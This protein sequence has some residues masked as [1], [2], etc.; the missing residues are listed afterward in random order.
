MRTR[1][2]FIIILSAILT[3]RAEAQSPVVAP[4]Q[5]KQVILTG[6]TIHTG[7]G[8]VIED[9]LVA[10]AAGKITFVGKRTEFS[11]DR[12]KAEVIDVTGNHV[13]PG[14]ILPNT[15]LGLVEISGVDV[16]VD[17]RETGDLNP[18]VRSIVAYNTDSHV[19]PVVRSNGV[20]IAQVVP[21]GTLLPGSATVVQLDAWNWED[22]IYRADNG[23][24]MG[25]PRKSA[26]QPRYGS[27]TP[28]AQAPSWGRFCC[29]ILS[30]P[31]LPASSKSC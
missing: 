4:A 20:L 31:R 1:I 19:I 3:G 13:Y 5:A 17:N 25:W 14:L 27:E 15:N 8:E 16:T 26:V 29:N 30:K 22:A 9:G 18:N 12:S 21:S 7:T 28:P 2:I 24:I 10:F 23:L 6:G 11:G